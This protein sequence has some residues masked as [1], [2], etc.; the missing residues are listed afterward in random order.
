MNK[1]KI[2]AKNYY[3]VLGVSKDASPE[4]IKKAYMKLAM[5]HHPDKNLNNKI[6]SEKKFKE[7]NEAYETLSDSQKKKNYDTY[8]NSDNPFNNAGGGRGGRQN[9]GSF[10]DLFSFFTEGGGEDI[11]GARQ[12]QK[13][14]SQ[15][16]PK[17]GH[18][19]EIGLT[20]TLKES[21]TGTK[22]KVNYSRFQSCSECKGMCGEKGEKPSECTQCKGTGVMTSQQ[23][24]MS[25]QYE[26]NKCDGEG[27]NIKNTCKQCKGSGRIRIN[28]ETLVIIPAG[29]DT[30]NILRIY[31]MGDAG[32]YGGNYGNLM[33]AIQVQKDKT[34]SRSENDLLSTLQLPYP[35]LVFGCEILV[36]L[37]DDS[38]ELLKIPSGCA[39]GEKIV[40]KNKGFFKAG[41]KTRGHFIVTVTCD[42]P[43]NLSINAE[44]NLKEYA[45]NLEINSK[46]TDGFLSGFFKKLF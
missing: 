16:S 30:G 19:V 37:I 39:V 3:D 46:K 44:N 5:Q 28:E 23:G 18:D 8:G 42:I 9:T 13:K 32:I 11:F 27:F 2:M 36:K 45:T 40:I 31:E 41:S 10:E 22:Q 25:V 21:F 20:I 34:F 24:W 33:V 14:R 29:I 17:N 6:E 4:E 38:E 12:K 26:C 35:H 1:N 15:I 43:K 7:I